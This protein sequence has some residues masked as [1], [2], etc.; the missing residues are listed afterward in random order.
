[1]LAQR[2][3]RLTAMF[4]FLASI[5][6]VSSGYWRRWY[7]DDP[8]LYWSRR[9]CAA[10]G[11]PCS[12]ETQCCYAGDTCLT[13]TDSNYVVSTF[14]KDIRNQ[15]YLGPRLPKE[16]PCQDSGQ[17]IDGCCRE[18]RGARVSKVTVCGTPSDSHMPQYTCVSSSPF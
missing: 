10:S 4:I 2:M 9:G 17:C 7:E 5:V 12:P 16:A 8:P 18:Y 3:V 6:N 11:Q 13:H 15:Q 1:M 14:C